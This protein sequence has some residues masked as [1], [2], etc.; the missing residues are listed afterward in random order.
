MGYTDQFWLTKLLEK[1]VVSKQKLVPDTR[2]SGGMVEPP[3]LT[4]Y[5]WGV[6]RMRG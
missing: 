2:E 3:W 6:L 1:Y 4:C 5:W